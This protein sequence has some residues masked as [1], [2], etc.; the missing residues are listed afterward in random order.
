MAKVEYIGLSDKCDQIKFIN[1]IK[2]DCALAV[3][4]L[5]VSSNCLESEITACLIIMDSDIVS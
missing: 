3:Y 4:Y 1:H 5:S 2:F